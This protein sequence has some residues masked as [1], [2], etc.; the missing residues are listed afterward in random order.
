VRTD[1]TT[2]ALT[3]A[4]GDVKVGRAVQLNLFALNKHGRS[5][6]VPGNLATWSSTDNRVAEVNHQGRLTP[7]TA[8]SVT[9]AA[10]HANLQATAV[11]TV[12]V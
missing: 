6:L 1:I 2:L 3:P 10:A 5:T 12:T 7:R 4:G 11:F 9:I 8:G